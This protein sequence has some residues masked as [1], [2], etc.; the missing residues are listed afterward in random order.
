MQDDPPTWRTL[1]TRRAFG[2]RWIGVVV[3]EVELPNGARYEYTRLE[4]AGVGVGVIGFNAAG[5][6][7]LEREYRHGVGAVI[8]QIPG[9]LATP[10]ED[11][12]AAGLRELLEETGYAPA[13][14][15]AE[16]VAYLGMVWDNPGFG[17]ACSHIYR[18]RGLEL[19]GQVNHDHSEFVTMHWVS[20]AWL[21]EAVRSGE[22]KDR[23]VV[24]AVAYLLLRG[25]L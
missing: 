8:W 13:V 2:N 23:V 3:D 18:A 22:I 6:L 17:P 12:Q 10:G 25:E 11:L 1:S 14:V 7:L 19:R 21:K 24:A 20:P 5:E 15:D 9:G 4:P 16:S